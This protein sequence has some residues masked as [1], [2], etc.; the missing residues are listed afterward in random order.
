MNER[1]IDRYR[2]CN[3]WNYKSSSLC[4]N[5][6]KKAPKKRRPNSLARSFTHQKRVKVT[7][8][9]CAPSTA[10]ASSLGKKKHQRKG[11]GLYSQLIPQ[12]DKQDHHGCRHVTTNYHRGPT[13][14]AHAKTV[15]DA[16]RTDDERERKA[17]PCQPV[18]LP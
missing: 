1:S 9:G 13:L 8:M 4:T 10:H 18:W 3:Q 17:G 6:H 5:L 11:V 12:N 16:R 15:L 14:N 7:V 2:S